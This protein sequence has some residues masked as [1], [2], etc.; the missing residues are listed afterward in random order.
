MGDYKL[1]NTSRRRYQR[2]SIPQ[3]YLDS[4]CAACLPPPTSVAPGSWLLF[5][6]V[7]V[8]VLVLITAA[9]PEDR[10]QPVRTI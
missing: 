6:D 7:S 10:R 1:C 5:N 4:K 8:I 3:V 9:A 2:Y